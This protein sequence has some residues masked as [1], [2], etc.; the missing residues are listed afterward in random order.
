MVTTAVRQY[1]DTVCLVDG[2][3]RSL[4]GRRTWRTAIADVGFARYRSVVLCIR[5]ARLLVV[6]DSLQHSPSGDNAWTVSG[7]FRADL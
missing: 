2:W 6:R 7:R 4:V 5:S 3:Q 1:E